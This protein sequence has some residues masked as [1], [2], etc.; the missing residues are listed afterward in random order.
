[1]AERGEPKPEHTEDEPGG[2]FPYD[3]RPVHPRPEQPDP[4]RTL[5]G[6]GQTE[7]TPM[8]LGPVLSWG[9]LILAALFLIYAV[10]GWAL[11]QI[12]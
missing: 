9:I 5:V 8:G 10:G 4:F 12:H 7:G 11:S 3:D 2:R 1:M 6:R